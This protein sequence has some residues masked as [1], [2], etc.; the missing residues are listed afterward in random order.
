MR[1]KYK[2]LWTSKFIFGYWLSNISVKIRIS[3]RS[4]VEVISHVVIWKSSSLIIRCWKVTTSSLNFIVKKYRHKIYW[5]L[6]SLNVS[7]CIF[8]HGF[9][10]SL[11]LSLIYFSFFLFSCL[12]LATP[13]LGSK[14]VSV[15]TKIVFNITSNFIPN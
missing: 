11:W 2:K 5:V 4:P 15:L 10:N 1:S 7:V 3:K 8:L 6:I 14:Q 13:F 12:K 9:Y